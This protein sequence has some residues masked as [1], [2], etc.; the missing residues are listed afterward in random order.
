MWVTHWVPLAGSRSEHLP[1][2]QV[3]AGRKDQEL[4]ELCPR[5]GPLL[6]RVTC[7]RSDWEPQPRKHL[8]CVLQILS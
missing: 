6:V 3:G 1:V 2:S 8:N 4:E 5:R 7:P